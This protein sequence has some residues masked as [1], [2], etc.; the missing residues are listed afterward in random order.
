MARKPVVT[1]TITSTTATVLAVDTVN[2]SLVE[3]TVILPRTY[4][5]DQAIKKAIARLNLLPDTL[6]VSNV[7]EASESKR[8]YSMPEERFVEHADIIE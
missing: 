1:R 3:K 5:D 4:K 8:R 7:K 6:V 2:E